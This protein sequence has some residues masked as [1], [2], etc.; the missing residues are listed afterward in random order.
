MYKTEENTIVDKK[1]SEVLSVRE[2]TE[3]TFVLR[4][5]RNNF[6]FEA[7]QYI[8]LSPPGSKQK[9]EYSIYSSVTLPYL[10]VLVK[11]VDHGLVS[12]KLKE[13]KPGDLIEI[14][15]PF[16]HFILDEKKIPGRKFLFIASGTGISPFHSM[17]RSNPHLSYTL[18]H[19][20]KNIEEGY[21][22]KDY[23][24]DQYIQCTS[25]DPQG[26]FYGRVTDYLRKYPV[27]PN[28]FCYLCGNSAMI[29]EAYS[30]LQSQGM[31]S[32]HIFTEIYF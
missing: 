9:R 30:I 23:E 27:N 1:L 16:G 20:V 32:E 3:S 31:P 19:G 6:D 10:E 26:R 7:G 22:K 25:R 4:F 5:T 12:H 14:E 11:E 18:L 21:E 2:L 24:P 13:C 17:I 28:N 15:G 8:I 29:D